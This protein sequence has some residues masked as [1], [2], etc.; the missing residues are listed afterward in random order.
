MHVIPCLVKMVVHASLEMELM[1]AHALRLQLDIIV[2]R[3]YQI[4]AVIILVTMVPV[5]IRI[6]VNLTAPAPTTL[7]VV[8][9]N[10][11]SY[12]MHA[13]PGLVKM[14]VHASLEM[15]LMNAHALRLPLDT[16]VR[17]IYQIHAVII[18][19]TMVPVVIHIWVYLI[20]PAPIILRVVFVRN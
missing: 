7:L 3:I 20:A 15:E 4:H 13:I 11:Y 2:R 16:I 12:L 9:V 19:V 14:V 8:S 10:I 1:N 17:R 6:W 18:L 5:A